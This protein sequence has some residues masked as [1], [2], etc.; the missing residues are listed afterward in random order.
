[1]EVCLQDT[2]FGLGGLV[3][4]LVFPVSV[5]STYRGNFFDDGW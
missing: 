5:S 3:P 4:A 1:M 2:N